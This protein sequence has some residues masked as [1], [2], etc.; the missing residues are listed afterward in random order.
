MLKVT[1]SARFH[2][3]IEQEKKQKKRPDF[4][5]FGELSD[6]TETLVITDYWEETLMEGIFHKRDFIYFYICVSVSI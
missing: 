6:R 1:S 2:V 3:F 5:H 4:S